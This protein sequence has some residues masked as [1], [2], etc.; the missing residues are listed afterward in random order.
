METAFKT[1]GSLAPAEPFLVTK[2]YLE[3]HGRSGRVDRGGI[4]LRAFASNKVLLGKTCGFCLWL[5][6][7]E[8]VEEAVQRDVEPL[9]AM[10]EQEQPER[11]EG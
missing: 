2:C 10:E 9:V 8:I 11:D 5:R 4:T 3:G 6:Q 7:A 1:P